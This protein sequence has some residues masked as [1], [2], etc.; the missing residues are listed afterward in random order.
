MVLR[1]RLMLTDFISRNL[2]KF[3]LRRAASGATQNCES[4][5]SMMDCPEK[6]SSLSIYPSLTNRANLAELIKNKVA[7]NDSCS[8]TDQMQMNGD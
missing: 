4:D 1:L 3:Q 5:R 6:Q 8:T 2:G 7:A